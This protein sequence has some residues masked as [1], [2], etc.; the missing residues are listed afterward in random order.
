LKPEFAVYNTEKTVNPGRYL[1]L[2]LR[3]INGTYDMMISGGMTSE[4]ELIFGIK[5]HGFKCQFLE[6]NMRV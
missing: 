5:Q 4:I 2:K 3:R 6:E 1:K